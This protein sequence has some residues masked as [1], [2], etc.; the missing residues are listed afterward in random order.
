MK[1]KLVPT[2]DPHVQIAQ[3]R[4]RLATPEAVAEWIQQRKD[5]YP[6]L[7]KRSQLVPATTPEPTRSSPQQALVDLCAY[8]SSDVESSSGSDVDPAVDALPAKVPSA[9][10]SAQP[11][12]QFQRGRCPRGK[13]CPFVHPANQE[14]LIN[15][16]QSDL[17]VQ[18]PFRR[19]G[20]R[21]QLLA[22]DIRRDLKIVLCCLRYI[23]DH[24]DFSTATKSTASFQRRP[25]IREMS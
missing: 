8:A 16:P 6:T 3:F 24:H 22:T 9:S 5:R 20:L 19:R 17:S 2:N 25:L 18:G 4:K 7:A 15:P 14:P 11:C 12:R 10:S 21:R 13:R 23:N 1:R